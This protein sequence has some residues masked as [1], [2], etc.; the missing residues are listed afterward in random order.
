MSA[1]LRIAS[2]VGLLLILVSL[3]VY[4]GVRTTLGS[5]DPIGAHAPITKV[6]KKGPATVD[7][8]VWRLDKLQLYTRL[9][10]DKLEPVDVDVP[11]GAVIVK[12]TLTLTATE[13]T[14]LNK[15]F[16]CEAVLRDDR[17]NVWEDENA[18]GIE[19]PT[20]CGDDDLKI[21]RGKPFQILKIFVIPKEAVPHIVGVMTPG[22][23][24]NSAKERL[25]ITP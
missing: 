24:N 13:R 22:T 25:L 14:K 12:V 7:T 20:Y 21:V 6:V 3:S 4:L 19:L 17:G 15:G 1:P 18:F 2:R 5:D 16:T 9:V 10:D 8:V 23:N 11:D